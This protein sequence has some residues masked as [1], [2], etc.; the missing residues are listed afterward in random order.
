MKI[1][2][3]FRKIPEFSN[4]VLDT[5]LFESK[6]PVMFTCKNKGD[7]YKSAKNETPDTCDTEGSERVREKF[8]GTF[9]TGT[10]D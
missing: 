2:N 4:I 10:D 7:L 1:E 6:Y 5:I 3:I 8:R 9:R